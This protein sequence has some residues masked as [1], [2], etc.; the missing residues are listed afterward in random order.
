MASVLFFRGVNVGGHKTF[1]PT[2]LARKLA[3]FDVVN[4][5]AA[6]TFVVRKSVSQSAIRTELKRHLKIE[7]EIMVCPGREVLDLIDGLPFDDEH[8][9]PTVKFYATVLAKRPPAAI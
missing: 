2:E 6:G 3:H 4:V 9:G 7:A 5:G 1:R 8:P